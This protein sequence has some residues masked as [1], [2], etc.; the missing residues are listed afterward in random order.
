MMI[1]L[2]IAEDL[3]ISYRSTQYI[4]VNV[5]SMKHENVPKDQNNLQ[6]R[7]RVKVAKEMFV[8]VA[9]NPKFINCIITCNVT[10]VLKRPR[11]TRSKIKVMLIGFFAYLVVVYHKF[12]PRGQT[13]IRKYYLAV[14]S[15]KAIRGKLADLFA[16]YSWLFHHDNAPTHSSMT[17]A[18]Y[19]D[20]IRDEIIG[21]LLYL[22]DLVSILAIFSSEF[23]IKNFVNFLH[24]RNSFKALNNYLS[25][26]FI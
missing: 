20:Q 22:L 16:E 8:N 17:V 3:H 15:R 19:F 9:E 5:L 25:I 1:P 12:I 2:K 14:L 18:D 4:L 13:L 21:L 11:Q 10:R 7:N 24:I 23:I 26:M 6:K